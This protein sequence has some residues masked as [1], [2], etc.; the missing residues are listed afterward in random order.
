M[1]KFLLSVLHAVLLLVHVMVYFSFTVWGQEALLM[2][3]QFLI[4]YPFCVRTLTSSWPPLR[5]QSHVVKIV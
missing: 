4:H 5:V 3:H 2:L 1:I